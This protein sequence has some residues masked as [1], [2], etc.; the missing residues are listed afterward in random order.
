MTL[1]FRGSESSSEETTRERCYET[2]NK[3]CAC[4]EFQL[5]KE[6]YHGFHTSQLIDYTIEPNPDASDDRNEPSQ[7]F[8]LAFSTA[9]VVILG[10]RLET[11]A[12]KL[13][14]NELAVV[15]ILP[16]RYADVD[17]FKTFVASITINPIEKE[18][19]Q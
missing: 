12:N 4:I 3:H 10:W 2:M 18:V 8:T 11:L 7:K 14:E 9:D 6:H 13:C 1:K 17:R 19:K 15:R 16:K 5:D